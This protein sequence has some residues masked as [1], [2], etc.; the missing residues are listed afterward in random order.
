MHPK[1]QSY[2][3]AQTCSPGSHLSGVSFR[4]GHADPQQA[5]KCVACDDKAHYS[6][7]LFGVHARAVIAAHDPEA[8]PLFLYLPSQD[9]HGP[10]DV[11]RVYL[12]PYENTIADPVRRQLAAK[13]SVLDELVANVT[14]AL[15]VRGML[16]DTLIVYTADNGGPV[17]PPLFSYQD[18]RM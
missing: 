8:S 17:Q 15:D 2:T 10:S 4:P 5:S 18:Y 6:T 16:A 1:H 12:S 9:T 13:L 14:Q 3:H 7:V 11:P